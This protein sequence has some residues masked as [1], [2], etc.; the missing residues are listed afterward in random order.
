MS[1]RA[2]LGQHAPASTS[3]GRSDAYAVVEVNDTASEAPL[4]QEL[5]RGAHVTGQC[6][7]S[8]A[9]D[10]RV[11]EQ[12]ALIDQARGER[13]AAELGTADRDVAGRFPRTP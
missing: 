12:M 11:Q 13:L 6:T 1:W 7:L 10:D 8:A 4:G 3:S 9:D 2:R 5:E